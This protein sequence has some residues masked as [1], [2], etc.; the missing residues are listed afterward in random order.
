M[1]WIYFIIVIA[2]ATV[3]IYLKKVT[4]SGGVSGAM[5]SFFILYNNWINFVLFG[6]FFVLGSLATK[7]RFEE[8]QQLGVSQENEGVRTWVNA[9]ANGGI[10]A[11][12]SL[13]A[14]LFPNY[15]S[16]TWAATAAIAAALSDTLSSELGNVYGKRYYDILNFQKGKRGADGVVSLE[17]TLF[18][19][20]GSFLVALIFGIVTTEYTAILPITLAGFA[21]N[22]CDSYLGATLQ[23]KGWINNHVVNFLNT[24]FAAFLVVLWWIIIE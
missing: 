21:G 15:P 4:I 7:W 2:L 9:T 5:I 10:P 3:S 17:G 20:F 1:V 18:G 19:L 12:F 24:T 6:L 11:F 16:L 8:K 13:L 22:L 23:R 14:L